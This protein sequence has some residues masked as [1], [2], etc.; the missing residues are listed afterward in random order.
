[1]S[2]RTRLTLFSAGAVA[3][4]LALASLFVYVSVRNQQRG[5]V[6]DSLRSRASAVS[7]RSRSPMRRPPR[8][9]SPR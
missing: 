1:M 8:S 2:L 3:L 5:S 4:A 9:G 6:D 7:A